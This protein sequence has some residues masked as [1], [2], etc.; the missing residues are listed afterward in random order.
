LACFVHATV[1]SVSERKG[2]LDM[3]CMMVAVSR[4]KKFLDFGV[5]AQKFGSIR[6]AR[7][8]GDILGLLSKT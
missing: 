5:R 8:G 2:F 7:E 3:K 1:G 4:E 6:Q